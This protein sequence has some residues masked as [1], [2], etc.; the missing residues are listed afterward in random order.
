MLRNLK[1]AT[2]LLAAFA[3]PTNAGV[4]P[5]LAL[6]IL[7]R[8]D[9]TVDEYPT[10]RSTSDEQLSTDKPAEFNPVAQHSCGS[11]SAWKDAVGQW[12]K[13]RVDA[14]HH[15]AHRSLV[16]ACVLSLWRAYGHN[17]GISFTVLKGRI[18]CLHSRC[19][20]NI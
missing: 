11:I 1:S 20:D 14:L 9:S 16:T 15:I 19:K 2:A 3:T 7:S 8:D 10:Y 6:N 17:D 4:L 12:S 18:R 13:S 5:Q